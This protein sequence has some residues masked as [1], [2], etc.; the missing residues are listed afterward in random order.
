MPGTWAAPANT[1]DSTLTSKKRC[2]VSSLTSKIL[3]TVDADVVD[4]HV[5]RR[6]RDQQL[7]TT[8][9]AADIGADAADLGA[10]D[11]GADRRAGLLDGVGVP[12]NR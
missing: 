5:D 8:F 10:V 7:R 9:G 1:A 2:Q 4:E 12:Y 3:R 11:R 6:Q